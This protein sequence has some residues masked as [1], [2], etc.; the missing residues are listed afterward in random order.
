MAIRPYD[1][2]TGE[3]P[4]APTTS[5]LHPCTPAPLHLCSFLHAGIQGFMVGNEKCN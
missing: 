1:F 3:W 5:P 2:C 4:F